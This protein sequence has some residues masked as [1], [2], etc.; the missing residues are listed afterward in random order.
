ME[1]GLIPQ[2]N[3]LSHVCNKGYSVYIQDALAMTVY[4]MVR[5]SPVDDTYRT[6]YL[7]WPESLPRKKRFIF[8]KKRKVH[9]SGP[10]RKV[11]KTEK[12]K[13]YHR[14]I[15]FCIVAGLEKVD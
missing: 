4:F 9:G 11:W 6:Y 13:R 2:I 3:K 7:L 15:Y 1:K 10:F 5:G 12:K 8:F 14:V